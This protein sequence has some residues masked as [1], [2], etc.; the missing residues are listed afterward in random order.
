VLLGLLQAI[1]FLLSFL[2]IIDSS[3]VSEHVL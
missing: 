3:L 2:R 1:D